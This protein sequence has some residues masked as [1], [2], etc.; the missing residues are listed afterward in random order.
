MGATHDELMKR[1]REVAIGQGIPVTEAAGKVI[2]EMPP[3]HNTAYELMRTGLGVHFNRAMDSERGRVPAAAEDE[4]EDDEVE[5]RARPRSGRLQQRPTTRDR[6]AMYGWLL[7]P[8]AGADGVTRPLMEFS[9]DDWEYNGEVA[10][11]KE[12]GWAVTAQMFET[13]RDQ[14]KKHNVKRTSELPERALAE[15]NVAVAAT[16]GSRVA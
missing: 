12:R 3:D 14:L 1:M 5:N 6:M 10:R 9:F 4:N 2:V 7:K 15:L 8:F 13:G 16:L 11:G